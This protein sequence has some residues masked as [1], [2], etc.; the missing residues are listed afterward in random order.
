MAETGPLRF[1]RVFKLMLLCMTMVFWQRV[2]TEATH[3][4]LPWTVVE[5]RPVASKGNE[6]NS[7]HCN[8]Q[9]QEE[10]NDEKNTARENKTALQEL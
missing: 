2:S 3:I 10:R 1:V 4:S 6:G 9:T 8:N 7:C 5:H